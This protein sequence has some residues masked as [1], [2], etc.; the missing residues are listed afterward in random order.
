MFGYQKELTHISNELRT[1]SSSIKHRWGL[2]DQAIA[3][4]TKKRLSTFSLD[5]STWSGT[6]YG[7]VTLTSIDGHDTLTTV[8]EDQTMSIFYL[9]GPT[10][11]LKMIVYLLPEEEDSEITSGDLQTLEVPVNY[12]EIVKMIDDAGDP[13]SPDI[14]RFRE[15]TAKADGIIEGS[16]ELSKTEQT[17]MH[18]RVTEFP[19][20]LLEPRYPW[21]AGAHHQKTRTYVPSARFR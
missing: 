4:A 18:R 14:L 9:R 20:S 21:T 11:L 13:S 6:A 10:A 12:E 2:I 7:A 8:D 16:F 1:L 17:Y 15:L 3:A 5:F 19:L